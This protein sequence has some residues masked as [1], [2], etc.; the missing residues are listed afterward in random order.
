MS[1]SFE[2]APPYDYIDAMT[3]AFVPA[4]CA[5]TSEDIKDRAGI[6]REYAPWSLPLF[7]Q[8]TINAQLNSLEWDS[9][10][11]EQ[12]IADD[13][14]VE[15]ID[16]AKRLTDFAYSDIQTLLQAGYMFLESEGI[17]EAPK[18]QKSL[19]ESG[20]RL[21]LPAMLD[22]YNKS[23]VLNL[24]KTRVTGSTDSDYIKF[25]LPSEFAGINEPFI[26]RDDNSIEWNPEL[27]SWIQKNAQFAEGC[28]AHKK[29]IE[30][31]GKKQLLTQFFWEKCVSYVF[32]YEQ[33]ELKQ[34][35]T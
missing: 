19:L 15:A 32:A 4:L 35:C 22:D 14:L 10:P 2:Q 17:S 27:R 8:S 26:L 28:P 24:L 29:I 20:N 25:S 12:R 21:L 23:H 33:V 1:S 5:V 18:I 7:S 34:T 31:N 13:K 9:L 11:L 6:S 16:F 3:A 30:Q